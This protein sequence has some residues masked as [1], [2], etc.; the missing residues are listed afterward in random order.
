[1][2]SAQIASKF[3]MCWFFFVKSERVKN[4]H[5]LLFFAFGNNFVALV[6]VLKVT[7]KW[8][9]AQSGGFGWG[10]LQ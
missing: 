4:R 5:L 7:A 8:I 1:M 3:K 9:Q 10:S 6:V 2:Y